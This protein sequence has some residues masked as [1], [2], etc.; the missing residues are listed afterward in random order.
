MHR[1]AAKRDVWSDNPL[2]KFVHRHCNVR[3]ML[4]I[5]K[6]VVGHERSKRVRN[7]PYA[8]IPQADLRVVSIHSRDDCDIAFEL[9]D[10]L[11][12]KLEG[13]R[14]HIILEFLGVKTW[15]YD[16]F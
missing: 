15:K 16:H 14:V 8:D 12:V 1:A 13:I 4:E 10:Q 7:N 3:S 5:V 11:W 6:P 2:Q 9:R